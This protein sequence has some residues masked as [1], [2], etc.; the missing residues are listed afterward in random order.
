MERLI[1][2]VSMV[3]QVWNLITPRNPEDGSDMFSEMSVQTRAT[4]YKIPE[5][6]YNKDL[7]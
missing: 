2:G 7:S 4:Q 6:I 3:M 1:S 5:G